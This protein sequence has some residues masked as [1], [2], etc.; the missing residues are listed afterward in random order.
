MIDYIMQLCLRGSSK[1]RRAVVRLL[2]PGIYDCSALTPFIWI[3]SSQQRVHEVRSCT[4]T[5]GKKKP[6]G[7]ENSSPAVLNPLNAIN[8]TFAHSTSLS[9]YFGTFPHGQAWL[10]WLSRTGDSKVGGLGKV[11]GSFAQTLTQTNGPGPGRDEL[12]DFRN[13]AAASPFFFFSQT[14]SLVT[15]FSP[16]WKDGDKH[17]CFSLDRFT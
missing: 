9:L 16:A 8:P 1:W 11:F 15:P 10:I 14:S 4:P 3:A 7:P 13:M 2:S 12:F 5:G 6:F 17:I